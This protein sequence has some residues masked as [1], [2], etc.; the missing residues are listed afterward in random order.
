MADILVFTANKRI[1]NSLALLWGV[2][3]FYYDKTLST[4][5]TIH[6][7]EKIA[8]Q[9]NYLEEQDMMVSVL[10]M[11]ITAKGMVNTIRI[12]QV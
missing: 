6:D 1:L 8:Y 4:D 5:E 3:P 9:N 12:T 11:P 2:V 10:S 7:I